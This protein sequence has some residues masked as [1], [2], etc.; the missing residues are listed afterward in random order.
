MPTEFQGFRAGDRSKPENA[1]FTLGP[2][3]PRAALSA[4]RAR[5]DTA[6]V[7]FALEG[8]GRICSRPVSDAVTPAWLRKPTRGAEQRAIGHGV[9]VRQRFSA[10]DSCAG[11]RDGETRSPLE[12]ARAGVGPSRSRHGPPSTW[13]IEISPDPLGERRVAE[14]ADA[15][16]CGTSDAEL[17][18]CWHPHS[19]RGVPG[20][21][22]T[23]SGETARASDQGVVQDGHLRIPG[24]VIRLIDSEALASWLGFEIVFVRRLVAERR[25]PFLKIGKFV[26]FDPDEV[27]RWIDDQRIAAGRV[28]PG[29]RGRW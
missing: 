24:G 21:V 16:Q 27:A 8:V 1:A 4:H 19:R 5:P 12:A 29:R 11:L 23:E 13:I 26:R 6:T 14:G 18:S 15:L 28:R 22:E 9:A 7:R 20:A 3:W 2:V 10:C 25:I 17:A